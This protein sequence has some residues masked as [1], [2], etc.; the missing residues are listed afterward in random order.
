MI[1][2]SYT[3]SGSTWEQTWRNFEGF[4]DADPDF[5]ATITLHTQGGKQ[6]L[7]HWND[8]TGTNTA[9]WHVTNNGPWDYVFLQ[10]QSQLAGF[11]SR[12]NDSDFPTAV[13]SFIPLIRSNGGKTVLFSTWGRQDSPGIQ[14]F[15]NSTANHLDHTSFAYAAKAHQ[16][17][18]KAAPCGEAFEYAEGQIPGVILRRSDGSHQNTKGA[19]LA[20]AAM[21][22]TITGRDPKVVAF[23]GGNSQA[24]ADALCDAFNSMIT[25]WKANPAL[26]L[27]STFSDG[28]HPVPF[29]PDVSPMMAFAGDTT[30]EDRAM[31][32]TVSTTI[33][34]GTNIAQA[35]GD[36]LIPISV[37]FVNNTSWSEIQ[38]VASPAPIT[39]SIVS[40]NDD[41]AFTIDGFG[42][43]TLNQTPTLPFPRILRVQMTDANNW[44]DDGVLT[45]IQSHDADADKL[46]DAWE[47]LHFGNIT[48]HG[49]YGDPDN[50]GYVNFM[51][52]AYGL[53]PNNKDTDSIFVQSS[54]LSINDSAV[55]EFKFQRPTNY[56]QLGLSYHFQTNTGLDQN[57]WSNVTTP[58]H[59]ITPAGDNEWVTYR[60][61]ITEDNPIKFCRSRA[62]SN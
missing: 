23:N 9:R 28:T 21:Y 37:P 18:V 52:V 10:E 40:G 35:H 57:G 17:S 61:P 53:D 38:S 49:R 33:Q 8:G 59:S 13:D 41:S 60:I 22:H 30:S 1:G 58:P 42:R 39:Y 62:Y 55:F 14:S 45:V 56:T 34:T 50:D 32:V 47:L 44:S 20:A 24:D 3:N 4:L 43:V 36:Y 6:L 15:G 19:Y 12:Y 2:N 11:A 31:S 26:P 54:F 5:E 51:E 25:A 46:D 29:Y 16:W 27:L 48:T 7:Q